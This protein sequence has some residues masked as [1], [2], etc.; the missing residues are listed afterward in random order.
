MRNEGKEGFGECVR[1][2]PFFLCHFP[3]L[4]YLRAFSFL[5]LPLGLKVPGPWAHHTEEVG[6]RY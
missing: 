1:L 3:L 5:G 2:L 6:M 4:N